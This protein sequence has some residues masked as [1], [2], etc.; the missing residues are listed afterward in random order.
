MSTTQIT[1][2]THGSLEWLQVRHRDNNGRCIVGASEVSTI[3]GANQ[4][5]TIADL[6][7]RKLLP[8]EVVA[9]NEAMR[10]GNVLEPALIQYASEELNEPLHTPDVMFRNDRIISTLDAQGVLTP[11][12]IVE[13]KTN[14]YW[15]HGQ[16]LPDAWF[17]QAQAQMFC[18]ETDAVHFV[19]LDRAMRLGMTVVNRHDEMIEAMTRHVEAFCQAI[20]EE[21]LPDDITLTA[22]QVSALF[23]QAEGETELTPTA[24]AKIEEWSAI[25]DALKDLEA[26]EKAVK[27][28]LANMMRDAE[29]GTVAGQRVLSFKTQTTKRF[30]TKAFADAYPELQAQFTTQSAYRVL[31]TV[32]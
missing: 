25:K 13:A 15:S 1:K 2:P 19:V 4:Y 26:K 7:V 8:P 6:A 28:E 17:W 29:F 32:K 9:P 23:P 3:V 27:D 22:P 30:D 11:T 20:D 10:R 12:L 31:R 18:T 21:R 5:E 14:N 16:Q 24:L